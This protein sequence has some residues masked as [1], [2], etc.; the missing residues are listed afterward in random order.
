M[1]FDAIKALKRG[2]VVI[3]RNRRSRVVKDRCEWGAVQQDGVFPRFTEMGTVA[4]A[5][6]WAERYVAQTDGRIVE[7][8][9]DPL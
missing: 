4:E 2:D 9:L 5:T 3:R 8:E 1:D 7:L 6:E